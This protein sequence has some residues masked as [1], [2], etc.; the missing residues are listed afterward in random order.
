MDAFRKV[1]G[2]D[3]V[4]VDDLTAYRDPHP[5]LD[6]DRTGP[7]AAVLPD[8]VEDVQ[9]IVRIAN[10][11]GVPLWTVSRGRNLGYGGAAPRTEDAVVVDLSRMNRILMVDERLC[12]AVVEPGVSYFDLH[13]ELRHRGSRLWLDVPDL[14][15][16]SVVGNT[17]ERGVG[18]TP[19]GDH[20]AAQCGMEVVLADGDILRTGMGALPDGETWPL[21]KY[22][23]G[24]QYDSMFTQSNFGIVTRMGLWLMPEPAGYRAF[25]VT[26]PEEDDL[27]PFI[28]AVR[29]LR[30]NQTIQSV[31]TLRNLM[32]DAASVGTRASYY[33]G[34]GPIP[35]RVA[36]RIMDEQ[37]IGR[38]NFY[39][40]LYG[41]PAAMDTAWATIRG[42]LS[43][44]HGAQFYVDGEH[45]SPV[46]KVRSKIM[47]GEPTLEPASLFDWIPGG[48]HV[49]VA[50]VSP[51]T[52]EDAMRLYAM[53]RD[54]C[55]EAG[56]DHLGMFIIGRREMHHICLMLFDT[57]DPEDRRV[58]RELCERL[59]DEAAAAGYG[60]YRVHPA[61]MDQVAATYSF[62]DHALMRLS[63]RIKD[64]LDPAG[65]LAPGKQGIWPRRLRLPSAD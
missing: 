3:W 65:I 9:A 21:Y 29:P 2:D 26:L 30:I 16:G 51:A 35:D 11:Y 41:T 6:P 48:G 1:V 33:T 5:I 8:R 4:R 37:R 25:L 7:A 59:I 36:R 24:P 45:P 52:G 60:K 61:F 32:L 46:L 42:A 10:E 27:A 54:R 23:F 53:A 58:T 14:G 13:R 15:W 50:P 18:Y 57:T 17:L 63:E 56:K 19:Y 64:A 20:L 47:A 49:D 38:W 39:G 43:T 28:E 55:H 12:Y 62:N 44:I 40:A 34:A 22:G 31:P